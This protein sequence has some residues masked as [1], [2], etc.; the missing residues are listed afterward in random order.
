MDTYR[1]DGA[2]RVYWLTLP[3]PR[4]AKRRSTRVVNASVAVAAP[5]TARPCGCST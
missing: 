2:A 4:D 3:L 5:P 1:R